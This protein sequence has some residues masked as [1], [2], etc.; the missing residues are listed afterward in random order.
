MYGFVLAKHVVV[1]SIMYQGTKLVLYGQT[2]SFDTG[3]V[4]QMLRVWLSL[5]CRPVLETSVHID[6]LFYFGGQLH[7]W[8]ASNSL[9]DY[10]D[11]DFLH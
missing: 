8:P 1:N 4:T 6:K 10:E 2:T 9:G 7:C 3:S 11:S 5:Q